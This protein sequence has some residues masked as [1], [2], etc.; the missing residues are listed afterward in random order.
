MYPI[1]ENETGSFQELARSNDVQFGQLSYLKIAPQ[2]SRGNHYHKRKEEWFCCLHG[3]CEME[4]TDIRSNS[5]RSITMNSSKRE[6]V[7]VN[8]FENHIITNLDS[9]TNCELLIIIS[10]EYDESD[11]DTFRIE[12]PVN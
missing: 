3:K 11:P 1:H 10:E 7:K 9:K 5:S 2:C 6:F 12:E 4:L 8:P